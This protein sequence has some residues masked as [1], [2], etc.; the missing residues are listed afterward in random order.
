MASPALIHSP[1]PYALLPQLAEL[2]VRLGEAEAKVVRL[3]DDLRR[4]VPSSAAMGGPAGPLCSSTPARLQLASRYGMAAEAGGGGGGG[5]GGGGGGGGG[6]LDG[7]AEPDLVRQLRSQC[8]SLA[9]EGQQLRQQLSL[10]SQASSHG[11]E[12]DGGWWG[13]RNMLL[14][15]S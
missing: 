11:G 15:V 3:G 1:T 9:A 4:S 10:A 12:Q 14:G 8:A 2:H 7:Q 5:L 6:E 13:W